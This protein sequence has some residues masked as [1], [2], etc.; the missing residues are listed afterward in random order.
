MDG[1]RIELRL[2][3]S[4]DSGIKK[5]NRQVELINISLSDG[6]LFSIT[7]FS[8]LIQTLLYFKGFSK[9]K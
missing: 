4:D 3:L 1:M 2:I 6:K 8:Q 7:R 5:Y 9:F